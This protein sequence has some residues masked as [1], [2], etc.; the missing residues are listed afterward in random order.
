MQIAYQ[1]KPSAAAV[2]AVLVPEGG[3]LGARALVL[4]TQLGGAIG[5]AVTAPAFKADRKSVV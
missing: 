3:K 4:D 1:P 5:R 2:I